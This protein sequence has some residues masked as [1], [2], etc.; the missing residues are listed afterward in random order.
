MERHCAG[1]SPGQVVGADREQR[2]D[3]DA[4]RERADIQAESEEAL[5]DRM[6]EF[7]LAIGDVDGLD[8][9]R[10]RRRPGPQADDQPDR[11]HVGLVVVEDDVNGVADQVVGDLFVEDGVQE[12]VHLLADVG[13]GLRSDRPGDVAGKTQQRQQQRRSGQRAPECRLRTHS[14]QRVVPGLGQRAVSDLAPPLADRTIGGRNRAGAGLVPWFRVD[15]S[16]SPARVHPG[17]RT[18]R[19]RE[20]RYRC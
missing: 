11:D 10:H 2:D 3:E 15:Q 12:D 20:R 9:R 8:E 7:V 18:L 4:R 5:N 1:N 13:G 17:G 19:L 16:G 6:P 14:E